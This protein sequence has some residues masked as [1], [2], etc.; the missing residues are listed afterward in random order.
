MCCFLRQ[1]VYG[2]VSKFNKGTRWPSLPRHRNMLCTVAS[3]SCGIIDWWWV[4]IPYSENEPWFVSLLPL[5]VG[6]WEVKK[7]TSTNCTTQF[8]SYIALT[9]HSASTVQS[10]ITPT[11]LTRS[12]FLSLCKLKQTFMD[13]AKGNVR[14]QFNKIKILPGLCD[15]CRFRLWSTMM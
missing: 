9:L 6:F 10:G 3:L 1:K 15:A 12:V 7:Q 8:F 14:G 11:S 2:V 4:W 5:L 13:V